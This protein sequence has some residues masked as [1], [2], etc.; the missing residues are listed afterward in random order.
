MS[1]EL[2]IKEKCTQYD[3][4]LVNYVLHSCTEHG[5]TVKEILI[6]LK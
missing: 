6:C 1:C 2:S 3:H 5:L 4:G